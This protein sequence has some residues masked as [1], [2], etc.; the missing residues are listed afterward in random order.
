MD[1]DENE[2]TCEACDFRFSV[3]WH[4]NYEISYYP[5]GKQVILFCPHCGG[6]LETA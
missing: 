1:D 4:M 5:I 2:L 6:E 3:I